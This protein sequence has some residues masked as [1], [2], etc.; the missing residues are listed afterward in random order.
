MKRISL[1]IKFQLPI[2]ICILVG[3]SIALSI[4]YFE[5]KQTA[6]EFTNI[7]LNTLAKNHQLIEQSLNDSLRSKTE[8][9]GRFM[10]ITARDSILSYDIDALNE[11]QNAIMLDPEIVFATYLKPDGT[12]FSINV[13]IPKFNKFDTFEFKAPITFYNEVL[14]YALI[15]LS[16]ESIKE[17]IISADTHKAKLIKS[18]EFSAEHSSNRFIRET[19]LNIVILL[20]IIILVVNFFF[21]I[22]VTNPIKKLSDGA[23]RLEK[24]ELGQHVESSSNDELGDLA[25]VFNSMTD[26]LK[27]SYDDLNTSNLHLIDATKA[28]DDFMATISHELRTPL[29]AIIGYSELWLDEPSIDNEILAD[30]ENIRSAGF[31][32]LTLVNNILDISKI[33]AGKMEL[34]PEIFSVDKLTRKVFGIIR[35]LCDKGSN[36]LQL[37]IADDVQEIYCDQIK[38]NQILLNLLSNACKF[39]QNGTIRLEVNQNI[40]DG[41]DWLI[42]TVSDT[43]IGISENDL[44]KLFEPFSQADSSTTRNYGGTGLGLV[45]SRQYCTLMGGD[46]TVCSEEGKGS[47]FT[48]RLPK[49]IEQKSEEQPLIAKYGS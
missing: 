31:Q 46:L 29:N 16:K 14:G 42:F 43:G 5:V 23:I 7:S 11:F 37:S 44:D 35:P 10:A 28:K 19:T 21:K 15:A 40:V 33:V 12:P 26:S 32:L 13:K 48:I 39:T 25:K 9:L 20:F 34:Y 22:F 47:D 6:N 41:A 17:K 1:N 2:I 18:I 4:I 45:I 49:N 36:T 24:G 3:V 30:F 27:K 38:L 8:S